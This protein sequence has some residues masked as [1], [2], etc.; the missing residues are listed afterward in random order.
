MSCKD[1]SY[2]TG[3]SQALLFQPASLDGMFTQVLG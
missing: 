2:P 1:H 3:C